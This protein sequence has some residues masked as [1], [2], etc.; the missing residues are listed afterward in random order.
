MELM[1]APWLLALTGLPILRLV[2]WSLCL[3]IKFQQRSKR[4]SKPKQRRD[5]L[6]HPCAILSILRKMK[7][8][9]KPA[10]SSTVIMG[11]TRRYTA[12]KKKCERW[13]TMTSYTLR[14]TVLRASY[15]LFRTISMNTMWL[16]SW[17]TGNVSCPAK[18]RSIPSQENI[19]QG[20]FHP[21][22]EIPPINWKLFL[23]V[24]AHP[25]TNTIVNFTQK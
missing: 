3:S 9:Y 23:A 16:A 5:W 15:S 12:W 21:K 22:D 17:R 14:L 7:I 1:K 20:G 8:F 4:W 11:R 19:R 25:F 24:W 2:S 13:S 18:I 6:T 10:Q